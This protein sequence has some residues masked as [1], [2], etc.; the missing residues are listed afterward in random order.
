VKQIALIRDGREDRRRL[1]SHSG[2]WVFCTEQTSPFQVT[3]L[4]ENVL[5]ST[6]SLINEPRPA[7]RAPKRL[8]GSSE[9]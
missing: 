5:S 1:E 9:A 3:A 7:S 8:V 6:A 4:D 2:A